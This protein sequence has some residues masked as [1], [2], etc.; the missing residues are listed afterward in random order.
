MSTLNTMHSIQATTS[1]D[2]YCTTTFDHVQY[3]RELSLQLLIMQVFKGRALATFK[4]HLAAAHLPDQV[5]ACGAGFFSTEFWVER[6]VQVLKRMIKYRSTAYP[7]LLFVHDWLLILACRKARRTE[8]GKDLATLDEALEQLRAAKRKQHDV[9]DAEGTEL[10]G[11]AK[12]VLDEEKAHV[13]PEYVPPASP[14]DAVKARGLPLL[15]MEDPSLDKQGWP[16]FRTYPHQARVKWVY[17]ELGLGGPMQSPQ[18]VGRGPL[19]WVEIH[20]FTR[21][22][23][24]INEA[25]SCV[26]CRTQ[27]KKNNQWGLVVWDVEGADGGVDSTEICAVHFQFFVQAK[28]RTRSGSD[29]ARKGHGAVGVAPP[30]AEAL[31]IAVAH[32][33]KCRMVEVPGMRPL[34]EKTAEQLR[35][36]LP[37]IVKLDDTRPVTSNAA[38]CGVWVLDLRTVNSQLVPTKDRLGSRNFMSSNKASGRNVAVK[39]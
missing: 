5:R 22:L 39:R 3:T 23:L 15:L 8:E 26:Q 24:P 20:K 36:D 1:I 6:L 33:F 29:R 38:Y 35:Q 13:L 11:A 31:K 16:T 37:E 7:E 25:I 14:L 4:L 21:A 30:R 17:A 12:D 18:P 34:N 32:V 10:L 2:L 9:P 19:L 27:T 28:Y